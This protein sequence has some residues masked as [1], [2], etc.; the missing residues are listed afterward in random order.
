LLNIAQPTIFLQTY[1]KHFNWKI[2]TSVSKKKFTRNL[3]QIPLFLYITEK[4]I[5]V[6]MM[7]C[8][9]AKKIK[10][11][12]DILRICSTGIFLMQKENTTAFKTF[13]P[14]PTATAITTTKSA[15]ATTTTATV[16]ST[17]PYRFR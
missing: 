8:K 6:H 13:N 1:L 16:T 14:P 7:Y 15:T 17:K 3:T 12:F 11:F 10:S 4:M 5:E 2:K 9:N